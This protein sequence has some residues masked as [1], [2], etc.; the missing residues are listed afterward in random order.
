MLL[1]TL[2]FLGWFLLSIITLGLGFAFFIPYFD[3]ARGLVF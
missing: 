3:S 2:S 1:F